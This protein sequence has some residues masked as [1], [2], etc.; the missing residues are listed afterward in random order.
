MIYLEKKNERRRHGVFHRQVQEERRMIRS[1][2]TL[3][4]SVFCAAAFCAAAHAQQNHPARP[5]RI[6]ILVQP[7][8][9]AGFDVVTENNQPE[10]LAK[11]VHDD[12]ERWR[13]VAK[14]SGIKP[15]N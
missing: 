10:D 3:L 6:V 8:G 4:S 2:L 7:G 1:S 11:L 14:A 12:I 15:E 5:V 9:A 13:K